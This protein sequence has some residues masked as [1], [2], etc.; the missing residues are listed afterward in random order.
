MNIPNTMIRN[1]TS[2]RGAMRSDGAAAAAII[3]G[4]AV[5]ALAMMCSDRDGLAHRPMLHYCG[6]TI[7]GASRS[8]SLSAS[9]APALVSTV[10]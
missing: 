2:R 7:I 5:V 1:A 10:A 4:G 8:A 3:V 9:L 6:W